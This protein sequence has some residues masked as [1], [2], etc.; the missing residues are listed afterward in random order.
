MDDLPYWLTDYV[1]AREVDATGTRHT[2]RV[3]AYPKVILREHAL[4]HSNVTEPALHLLSDPA[5]S[6][7]NA[8]FLMALEDY[9]KGDLGDCVAK[10]G[11]A[12]ESVL[13]IICEKK[14]WPY[15]QTDTAARLLAT[16][17]SRTTLDPFFEQPL[18]LIATIRN[19][20][21]T[22]HGAGVQPKSVSPQVARF[23]LNA[24]ATAILLLVEEAR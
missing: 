6:S 19:R 23:A 21:S 3:A 22:A 14:R 2:I 8:E 4:L 7:A 15:Q 17:L 5:F 20:R 11:S 10:C 24:T 9:R 12:F 13:K 18:L 1:E 16:V